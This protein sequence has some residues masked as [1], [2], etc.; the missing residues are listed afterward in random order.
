MK[1][2]KLG[3]FLLVGGITTGAWNQLSDSVAPTQERPLQEPEEGQMPVP[4]AITAK[5]LKKLDAKG[6]NL[7]VTAAFDKKDPRL[8]NVTVFK[9][10]LTDQITAVLSDNGTNGDV[11]ANDGIF[12]TK[13]REDEQ[14]LNRTMEDF[15][16]TTTAKRQ[17]KQAIINFVGRSVVSVNASSADVMARKTLETLITLAPD[18]EPANL[19]IE[20]STQIATAALTPADLAALKTN[21]LIVNDLR[22]VQDATRTY[23]PC[24]GG[25]TGGNPNGVWTFKSLLTNMANTPVTGVSADDFVKNWLDTELFAQ[26]TQAVSLDVTT[27]TNGWASVVRDNLANPQSSKYKFIAAWL[28][29]SGFQVTAPNVLNWKALLVNKLEFIPLRLLAIV[30]RLDLRGNFAYTGGT[31]SGGEGRFVFCFIDSNNGCN[32]LYNRGS[33]QPPMEMTVI[34]EYGIP[35][36]TCSQLSNYAKQWY[37]LKNVALGSAAYNTALQ[38][39]TDV[40]TKANAGG[41]NRPNRS[42]L[43]HLR[44]NEALMLPWNIRDFEINN[45]RPR[46]TGTGTRTRTTTIDPSL[47]IENIESRRLDAPLTR[48]VPPPPPPLSKFQHLNLIHPSHEPMNEANSAPGGGNVA[49]KVGLLNTFV[50]TNA[51]AIM[52]DQAY[53]IP[54]N[55]KGVDAQMPAPTYYWNNA[56]ITL[57]EARHKLS[58]GT[59]SGCHA[60]ETKTDFTHVKPANFGA[61]A[62]LS[63]FL[64]GLG[65]DDDAGDNDGDPMAFL[66]VKDPANRPAS[67]PVKRGFNDLLRR[68]NDLTTFVNT[69]CG[70]KGTLVSLVEAL[71]FQK[72][73]SPH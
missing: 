36:N 48:P 37:N 31:T 7:L 27:A 64:T 52:S 47:A 40:F 65:A 60:G 46:P 21:S 4:T 50:N 51:I 56:G 44:T 43:N 9:L 2:L 67:S 45:I 42:A 72:M 55:I 24:I 38:T 39:I 19:P 14:V 25:T 8:N 29:N 10:R 66:W 5:L 18:G 1:H 41:V 69:A 6:N 35:L 71:H 49:A 20:L 28:K 32:A 59:C 11:K 33:N 70:A 54:N 73:A 23:N 53:T 22:V 58:L 30:N 15:N 57:D 34:L 12:T 63:G 26:K 68:A 3:L 13:L 17:T 16:T 61:M 62:P